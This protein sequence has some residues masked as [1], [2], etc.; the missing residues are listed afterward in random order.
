M[1]HSTRALFRV[2]SALV[3]ALLA[4]GSA[5][6]GEAPRQNLQ[7]PTL[8]SVSAAPRGAG[9]ATSARLGAPIDLTGYWVAIVNEEWRWRMVTPP[10]GD[11]A[12]VPLNPAGRKVADTWDVSQDGSCKAYGAAGL[13]RLPTRLHITWEGD[14]VLKL[15][16]DA[17]QQTRRFNF[18]SPMPQNFTVTSQGYSVATW[19]RTLPPQGL[20]G[21]NF[22]PPPPS[23]PGGSLQVVTSGLTAGWLRRNGVPYSEATKVTEYYDRFTAPNKDEWL[24]VT[25]VVEDPQYLVEPFITSSHFRREPD[26]SKWDPSPCKAD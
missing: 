3:I 24:M 16:T 18:G 11:Y 6:G 5:I 10:K 19:Q 22:G 4:T 15:E 23:P 9:T 17:G 21:F 14:E 26:G 12:S 1:I 20:M 8:E 25:T 2:K 7:E 13:M